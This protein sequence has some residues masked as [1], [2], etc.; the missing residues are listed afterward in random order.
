MAFKASIRASMQGEAPT[1][2]M[3]YYYIWTCA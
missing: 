3:S 1:Q 2:M